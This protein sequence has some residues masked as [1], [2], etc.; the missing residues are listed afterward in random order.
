MDHPETAP[1][2]GPS[3]NQP[4]VS[5]DGLVCHQWKERTIGC[6]NIICPRTGEHQGQEVGVWGEG[7]GGDSMGDVWDSIG[8][9]NEENT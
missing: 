8:N 2:G 4:Y 3:H 7:S 6:A 9:V 1:L 5:E